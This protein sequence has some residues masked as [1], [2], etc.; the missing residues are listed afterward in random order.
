MLTQKQC[1]IYPFP[2]N[3]KGELYMKGTIHSE[4]KCPLCSSTFKDNRKNA[5]VCPKHP[6]QQATK[7][8]VHF[9]GIKKRFQSYKEASHF[10]NGVRYEV[11][12]GVFDARDY[13][14]NNPLGF[15]TLSEQWL[16][17]KENEVKRNSFRDINN[18]INQAIDYFENRN[19]KEIKPKDFQLFLNSLNVSSKTKHN[20][21]STLKQFWKWL[22]DNDEIDRLPKF[23]KVN[24]KLAWRK[25][26]NKD[27][28][29]AIID[30]VKRISGH[31][32]KIWLGI[33]FLS[34][35]FNTRP[36]ELRHALEGNIDLIQGKILLTDTKDRPKYIYLIP[37]DINLLKSFP[38]GMPH[39]YFFRH[40]DGRQ[41][42]KDLFYS[43]WKRACKNLKIENVDLY[44]GTRHSTVSDLRKSRTP[45][46]IRLASMHTTNKAF[47]RYFQVEPDDLRSIYQ[48]TQNGKESRVQSNTL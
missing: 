20:H 14:A 36:N 17:I 46:E 10:L 27:T 21:I 39:L 9:R 1:S 32:L 3:G 13:Q 11:N 45:E 30:E 6:E 37:E 47:D 28:Q 35:Y 34:T 16:E 42:G 5:L 12:K 38:K 4:Q 40:K 7:F 41:F 23:P 26:V 33:K 18:T 8:R 31:N 24:Y 19:I 15:K 48:D 43:Y 22:F 25:T 44:G 29:N 2:K